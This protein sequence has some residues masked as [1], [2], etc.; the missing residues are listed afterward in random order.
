M[1]APTSDERLEI[2][3]KVRHA[4]GIHAFVDALGIDIDSDWAWKDVSRRVAELID[5]EPERTCHIAYDDW[6]SQQFMG[7]ML[8]CDRCGAAFPEINGPYQYCPC[9]G[10][11]VVERG[12]H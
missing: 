7:P 3:A 2:A 11:R 9:C 5:Q 1:T 8:S 6:A 4:N 10:A 12:E